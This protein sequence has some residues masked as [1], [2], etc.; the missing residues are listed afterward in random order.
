RLQ[1]CGE[2]AVEGG[3]GTGE[4][5]GD[6]W[7]GNPGLADGDFASRQQCRKQQAVTERRQEFD[8]LRGERAVE[9]VRR[10]HATFDPNHEP[11][12]LVPKTRRRTLS[13]D[14]DVGLCGVV[15]PEGAA[16]R[17]VAPRG[18]QA[19][20]RVAE[21]RGEI[22]RVDDGFL[23]GGRRLELERSLAGH[24]R[25]NE[26]GLCGAGRLGEQELFWLGGGQRCRNDRGEGRRRKAETE[27]HHPCNLL[28]RQADPWP[29]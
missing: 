13:A 15:V 25:L 7:I 23:A 19:S 14:V 4:S 20:L 8:L 21:G 5:G 16:G 24:I 18:G 2:I 1:S 12:T 9:A 3:L 17:F 6:P 27:G 29:G 26:P 11:T 10:D 28:S 22:D